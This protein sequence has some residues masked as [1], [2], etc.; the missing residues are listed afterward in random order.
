MSHSYTEET[1][2]DKNEKNGPPSKVEK[3][4]TIF[5]SM[6][7]VVSSAIC[8]VYVVMMYHDVQ[9]LI[10]D[11]NPVNQ[12]LSALNTSKMDKLINGIVSLEECV[13]QKLPICS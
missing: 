10:N 11:L 9:I 6:V 2:L 4:L 13:L 1:F 5:F 3:Y 7:P 8:A 12:L